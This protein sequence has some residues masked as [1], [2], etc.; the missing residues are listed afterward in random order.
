MQDFQGRTAFMTR[1]ASNIGLSLARA[2]LDQ[3]AD[4][5]LAVY[6]GLGN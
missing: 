5:M 1:T 3:D 4:V 6:V 2:Y